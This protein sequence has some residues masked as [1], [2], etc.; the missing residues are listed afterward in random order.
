MGLKDIVAKAKQIHTVTVH[1]TQLRFCE[2]GYNA[3]KVAQE[4]GKAYAVN[5]VGA[6]PEEVGTLFTYLEMFRK[7]GEQIDE[8]EFFSMPAD[9]HQEIIL[10]V[11]SFLN[12]KI[13][14]EGRRLQ[15]ELKNRLKAQKLEG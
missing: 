15:E 13:H 4:A 8:A 5:L 3:E 7:G 9:Y 14:T 12:E 1:G 10:A 11:N 2:L 6:K